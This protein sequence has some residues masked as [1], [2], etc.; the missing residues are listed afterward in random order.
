VR[1]SS[2]RALGSALVGEEA[3]TGVTFDGDSLTVSTGR[4]RELA[5]VLP[6]VAR[7]VGARLREVRP[8]DESLD[9]IFRDLIVQGP[10]R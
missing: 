3:V 4:A 2:L 6:R 5:L 9:S 10:G 8:L 7:A 1:A